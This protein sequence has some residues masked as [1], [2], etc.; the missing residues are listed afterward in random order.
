M[1]AE[2]AAAVDGLPLAI[3]LAA[4][5]ARAYSLRIALRRARRVGRGRASHHHTIRG[6]IDRS[7]RALSEPEAALH[8]RSAWC[9]APSPPIS[10]PP[11]SGRTR[12]TPPTSSPASSTAPC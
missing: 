7:Y 5:R 2:I 9:P 8:R 6:A 1:A 3:E 4:G 12:A 10:P 11:W